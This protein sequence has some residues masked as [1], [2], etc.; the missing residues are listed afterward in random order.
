MD[1]YA[2]VRCLFCETGKEN[3]V[4]A[5]IQEKNWGH[6][7]FAQRM[8]WIKRNKEW[9]HVEAP[10]FPGY[11]FVYTEREEP[12]GDH[13]RR[14]PHV[15][16]VLAYEDGADALTGPDLEF[17]DWLWRM[18]GRIDVIQAAQVG[19]R[20]EIADG[21]LK[22]LRGTILRLNKR[23]RKM[24]VSLDTKSIPMQ[25]WLTYEL[26]ESINAKE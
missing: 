22:E 3:R 21:A 12:S 16:R 11:V 5:S 18:N 15:I 8:R 1:R 17:A 23:Q 9:I 13:Y 24:L 4:V 26:V 20:V 10:L 2:K 6:P 14:M 7:I 25:M 19:N